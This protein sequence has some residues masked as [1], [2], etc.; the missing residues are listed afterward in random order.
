MSGSQLYNPLVG[1]PPP[2]D[3]PIPNPPCVRCAH[4]K[5]WHDP[6]R[7]V[8]IFDACTCGGFESAP[9]GAKANYR[10]AYARARWR[11]GVVEGLLEAPD[12]SFLLRLSIEREA[13]KQ[14]LTYNKETG[15]IE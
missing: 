14:G 10:R 11:D 4:G 12:L 6:Y 2:D 3:T 7:D 8:C 13:K 1:G 9:L 5:K 15:A